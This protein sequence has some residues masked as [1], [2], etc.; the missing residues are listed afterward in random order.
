MNL[1]RDPEHLESA[2][3]DR[4]ADDRSKHRDRPKDRDRE[5]ERSKKESSSQNSTISHQY[6]S[7]DPR[8]PNELRGLSGN[9]HYNEPR[10]H[11]SLPPDR[12][13]TSSSR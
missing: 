12:W 11:E 9:S 5:R 1:S 3:R 8:G 7:H 13:H 4:D 10:S 6:R 2:S